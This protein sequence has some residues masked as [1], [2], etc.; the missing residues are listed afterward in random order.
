MVF[1]VHGL[2]LVAQDPEGSVDEDHRYYRQIQVSGDGQLAHRVDESPV[3]RDGGDRD[4]VQGD[5]RPDGGRQAETH[6]IELAGLQ[7]PLRPGHVELLADP[8]PV[9]A[10]VGRH[11]HAVRPAP[12][13]RIDHRGRAQAT[14]GVVLRRGARRSAGVPLLTPADPSGNGLQHGGR[15]A[16]DAEVR[17]VDP[18]DLRG[19]RVDVH[20]HRA[21]SEK[22][23]APAEGRLLSERASR[24]EHQVGGADGVAGCLRS[25]EAE[26]PD[27][28]PM[29]GGDAADSG[30]TGGDGSA[31]PL[32]EVSQ[33][34]GAGA[35]DHA[36][37]GENGRPLRTLKTRHELIDDG[38]GRGGACLGGR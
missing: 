23:A 1:A 6:G 26:H 5:G 18:V 29:V 22:V 13:E 7:Q 2:G 33:G 34:G 19:V 20:Q 35:A 16:D 27:A 8:E 28:A 4:S 9:V 10:D 32:T 14:G 36:V 30:S 15:A 12:V 24:D 38:S 37:T 25:V 21:F 17:L 11:Q 3:S 31:E